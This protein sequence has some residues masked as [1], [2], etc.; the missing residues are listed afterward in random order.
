[1]KRS[2]R[3]HTRGKVTCREE[4][5]EKKNGEEE[6]RV[7]NREIRARVGWANKRHYKGTTPQAINVIKKALG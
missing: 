5:N 4:K 1:M 6:R 7:T 2:D 3:Y